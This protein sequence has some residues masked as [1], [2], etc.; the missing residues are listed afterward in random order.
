V[1]WR[2]MWS[3]VCEQKLLNTSIFSTLAGLA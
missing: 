1:F 3:L 2:P